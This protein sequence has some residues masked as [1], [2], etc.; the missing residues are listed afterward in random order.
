MPIQRHIIYAIYLLLL[1]T[2][3][4]PACSPKTTTAELPVE[5]PAAFSESGTAALPADWWTSFGDTALNRVIDTALTNNFNLVV[6]W[7]RLRAA[8]AVVKRASS[9]LFPDLQANV[10][11]GVNFPQPDFVGGENV[12]LG[13]QSR[14][15][16]DLWGRIHSL[17][18][19]QRFRRRAS[20]A[21]YQAA[22]ISLSAEVARLWYQLAEARGQLTIVEGQLETNNKILQL[23]RQRLG[24]GQVR[25]VDVLRQEQLIAGN[26][27]QRTY[28]LANIQLLENQLSLLLGGR[29]QDALPA[30]PDSLIA[31]PPL[32]NT[33]IPLDLVRQR[34][35]LQR[36][37]Y[38]VQAA[39]E[40]LAAAISN[41]YPRLSLS[42]ST[43]L[44]ANNIQE[45]LDSW[46]YSLAGNIAAPLLNAGQ[47]RAEVDRNEAVRQQR[48]YEYGQATLIAFREVE[49]ALIQEQNQAQAIAALED[50]LRLANQ[51]YEQLRVQYFNGTSNYLD[52][53]TALN[54]MQQL[55]RD[56]LSARYLL[57]DYRIALCRALASAPDATPKDSNRTQ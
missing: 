38:Q 44:R 36:A 1:I 4:L 21:D 16:V 49:D 50:Q 40:E 34:P 53:L 9:S 48:L 41:K 33:G 46:A 15:E 26:R 39:D 11:S 42:A 28:V 20:A 2:A 57:L 47:L 13:L 25:G 6:A 35:D 12:R 27:E 43:S 56:L 5:T 54:Q 31:P 55:R 37:F 29:P 18:D 3:C 22:A 45:V 10:Q 24:T 8:K 17:V 51:S 32:P 30:T 19:A 14:Y 52:V 23:I 7:E